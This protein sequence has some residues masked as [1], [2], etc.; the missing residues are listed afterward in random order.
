[1]YSPAITGKTRALVAPNATD[2]YV[3]K[4]QPKPCIVI[5]IHGVNDLA[6]VYDTLE[7]GICTGLN[8]R[9]DHLLTKRGER[10]PAALNPA[11]Y[12]SPKDDDGQAPN[13]DAVYYRRLATKGKY[14]G[15]SRS[16]VIPFYWGF[17]E[18]EGRIQKQT[19]HG[20]WLDRFGNR[21]DK[22]GTKEGGA[23]ANATT[24]LPDMFGRGFSGKV[25]GL[26][27]N[28]LFGSP[29][30]PLFPAPSRLYMV[31]AAQRLA[32][33][34]KIIRA[35]QHPDGRSG[36][37]D[38]IN[39]VG[40]SQGNLITLLANAMLHDEGLRPIDGFVLMSPPYSLEETFFER[41]E[42][43]KAQQTT[44][45]RVKT[46]SN[47][48]GFIGAH[49]HQT[50]SLADMADASKDSCIGGLRWSGQ[51]CETSI[52]GDKVSFSERDNR[53]SVF[54]YFSPQDQTVGMANVQGIGWQGV[55]ENASYKIFDP[56]ASATSP[57]SP[58]YQTRADEGGYRKISVPALPE[59]GKRFFQRVFTMREREGQG[60]KVGKPPTYAYKLVGHGALGIGE[61]TWEGTELGTGRKIVANADFSAG[62]TVTIQ[63]PALPVPF[64][65]D[66]VAD[67]TTLGKTGSRGI[68][69]VW[70]ATDPID[71]SISITNGGIDAHSTRVITL[72]TDR[73]RGPELRRALEE[74]AP[75]LNDLSRNPY[76]APRNSQWAADWHRVAHVKPLGGGRYDAIFEESPNEARRRMMDAP[77]GSNEPV[78]FHS[79]IPMSAR[80]SRRG[81]AY[82]LAIGQACS[83]DDE[84]F[85]A[86][87]CR[88]ADWRLAWEKRDETWRTQG[89]TPGDEPDE[90]VMQC[91]EAELEGNKEL[92]AA[93]SLYRSDK[94]P[95]PGGP[96]QG[97]GFL[98]K[99]TIDADYPNLVV[100]QRLEDRDQGR[101]PQNGPRGNK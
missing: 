43:G 47:I 67:G 10:S 77:A 63:A 59:L 50:P 3:Q 1:M 48:I 2:A 66:F 74:K 83:I 87:L 6:G 18:E 68:K 7:T 97:G 5:L 57:H 13:P 76:L 12:T 29:D 45:A 38:T 72:P 53:G 86:Y 27:A 22:A 61:R 85:Y 99:M 73:L 33:L 25:A 28:A 15:H 100:W 42:L 81:V 39:V 69:P 62:Q 55:G 96:L 94:I 40:H 24:T 88:V 98:P 36:T 4:Q 11:R 60:E 90:T 31:L 51:Q 78:S 49:A 101:G 64:I 82:D 44:P 32:M 14:G 71:A 91:Y 65:P 9:L 30:H 37:D 34:V 58:A 70:T 54:L 19:T 75:D 92:I 79:A 52:D 89:A 16:V 56:N 8:E 26:P 80:H 35:Y 20:E 41:R 21:L 17:R 95:P 46:L 84:V 93:T 23:F